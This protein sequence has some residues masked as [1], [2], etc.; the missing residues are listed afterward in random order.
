MVMMMTC[1]GIVDSGTMATPLPLPTRLMSHFLAQNADDFRRAPLFGNFVPCPY[2]LAT[3]TYDR[4]YIVDHILPSVASILDGSMWQL[5]ESDT[6]IVLTRE[7][8]HLLCSLCS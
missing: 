3:A 6:T 5:G 8:F 7:T 1:L 2:V 4:G